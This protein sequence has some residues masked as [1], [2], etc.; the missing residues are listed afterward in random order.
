MKQKIL[1]L[2]G[3][4]LTGKST[5]AQKWVNQHPTYKIISRDNVREMLFGKFRMGN[6][7]EEYTV[8]RIMESLLQTLTKLKYN[9]VVDNT[10]LK[11]SYIDDIISSAEKSLKK[12]NASN[13]TPLEI[14]YKLFPPLTTSEY[15][16]R[17]RQREEATGKNIPAMVITKQ[18]KQYDTLIQSGKLEKYI[19]IC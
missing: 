19:A 17:N 11:I 15:E 8:S 18:I 12:N 10:N 13:T 4:S 5:F 2:V 16:A 7:A 3:T 14:Q 1:F 6:N 9:V